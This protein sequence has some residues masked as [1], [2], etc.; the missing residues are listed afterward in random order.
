MSE[1]VKVKHMK[2]K[3]VRKD[4]SR[5]VILKSAVVGHFAM[6]AVRQS[7][8]LLPENLDKGLKEFDKNLISNV[9]ACNEY[10]IETTY[11]ELEDNIK[12]ALTKSD[13]ISSWNIAKKGS[14]SV[15]V[16]AYSTPKPDYDFI[17][18]DALT[19]NIAQSV[20]LE[21]CYDEGA[22]E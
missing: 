17:D 1:G 3:L 15:F 4:I 20:W 11:T 22:F 12:K 13:I 8:Y 16:S 5:K 6:W 9:N 14:G 19:G 18:L 21:L 2:Q 10:L 7:P